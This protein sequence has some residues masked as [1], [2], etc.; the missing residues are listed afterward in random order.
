M[1]P[2][3]AQIV[4]EATNKFNID[5]LY[6]LIKEHLENLT[7]Q[8]QD[9]FPNECSKSF[10]LT[11]NPFNTSIYDVP[12]AAE[13]EFI[14]LKNN[15]EAKSWFGELQLQEF[16]VKTFPKFKVLSEIALRNLLPFPTTYLCETAFSQLLHL[17]SKYR[18]KLNVEDDLRCAISTTEN[19]IKLLAEKLQYQPSH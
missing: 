19:R 12:E 1:F 15:F 17:K 14:D 3:L 8:I 9:Y 10:S 6:G 2:T 11:I 7:V 16:W 18:N 13:E 4:E 5:D